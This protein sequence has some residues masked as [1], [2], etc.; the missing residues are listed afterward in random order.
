MVAKQV[1]QIVL[2]IFP[3]A[4]SVLFGHE[5]DLNKVADLFQGIADQLRAVASEPQPLS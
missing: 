4:Y 2:G 1:S 5:N 3:V